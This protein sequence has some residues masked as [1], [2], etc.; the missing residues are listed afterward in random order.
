M[1]RMNGRIDGNGGELVASERRGTHH[2]EV[3]SS[4]GLLRVVGEREKKSLVLDLTLVV[5]DRE[6]EGMAP[7]LARVTNKEMS[8]APPKTRAT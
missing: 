2:R 6:G 8:A 3:F 5:T 7:L 1:P 4:F